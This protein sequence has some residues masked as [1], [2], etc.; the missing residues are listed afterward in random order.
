MYIFTFN[1]V[2]NGLRELNC[3]NSVKV[4]LKQLQ[5][6]CKNILQQNTFLFCYRNVTKE[7]ATPNHVFFFIIT[8]LFSYLSFFS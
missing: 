4:N 7:K 8:T 2:K 6:W 1:S 3:L 5:K